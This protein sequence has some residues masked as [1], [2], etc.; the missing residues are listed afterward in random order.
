MGLLHVPDGGWAAGDLYRL[1][2]PWP[3]LELGLAVG[4]DLLHPM[5]QLPSYGEVHGPPVGEMSRRSF[6]R[7]LV[8]V[9]V[10]ILSIEFLAGT[11]A[12]LWPII[13]TG[14]GGELTIG[15]AADIGTNEPDW[16]K[17]LPYAFQ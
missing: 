17:G 6:M 12:F 14:L 15:S 5:S 2:L 3:R 7:R 8:G 10:G 16:V 11:A 13:R 4:R 9:G 1:I